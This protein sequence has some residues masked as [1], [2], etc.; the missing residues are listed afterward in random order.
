MSRGVSITADVEVDVEEEH[1]VEWINNLS[2]KEQVEFLQENF[3]D[4]LI[5]AAEDNKLKKEHLDDR[6]KREYFE[7]IM[8][9]YSIS[10]IE[11]RLP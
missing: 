11:E 1:V 5:D 6:I 10:D 2:T 4:L 8:D 7:S 3:G 9:K